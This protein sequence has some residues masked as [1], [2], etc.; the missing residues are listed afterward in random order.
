VGAGAT[1]P[2]CREDGVRLQAIAT[3]PAVARNQGASRR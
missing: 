1:G 3:N 2:G